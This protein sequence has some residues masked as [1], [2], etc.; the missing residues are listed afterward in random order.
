MRKCKL[1]KIWHQ[2]FQMIASPFLP[3]GVRPTCFAP[4]TYL[5]SHPEGGFFVARFV[6][7][8]LYTLLDIWR[9]TGATNLFI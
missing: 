3:I 7:H 8:Y 5:E 2:Y 1:S 9:V 6:D 4:D